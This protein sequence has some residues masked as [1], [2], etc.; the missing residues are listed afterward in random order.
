MQ[1]I[2]FVSRRKSLGLS[3]GDLGALFDPPVKQAT[4]AHW[5]RGARPIPPGIDG[6]LATLEA[7]QDDITESMQD[8]VEQSSTGTVELV[9]P[10]SNAGKL[11]LDFQ[12]VAAARALRDARYQ[13]MTIRI[14]DT[15]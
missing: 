12:G 2:E 10:L 11:P 13:G 14:A 3:Q 4:I 5:E 15:R 7:M 6:A 9:L 1:P 8:L